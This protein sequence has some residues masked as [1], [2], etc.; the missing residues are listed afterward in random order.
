[1]AVQPSYQ[2]QNF[3][4]DA[5]AGQVLD[6]ETIEHWSNRGSKGYADIHCDKIIA[7]D[8]SKVIDWWMVKNKALTRVSFWNSTPMHIE[9]IAEV[10]GKTHIVALNIQGE[11][12]KF[13]QVELN[14]ALN[15][16]FSGLAQ[17]RNI[18]E[19]HVDG[20]AFKGNIEGMRLFANF[21]TSNT[22][23]Q[24]IYSNPYYYDSHHYKLL[25]EAMQE[26]KTILAGFSCNAITFRSH[27][28]TLQALLE[29]NRNLPKAG[30]EEQESK[31]EEVEP[32]QAE[33]VALKEMRQSLSGNADLHSINELSWKD[34]PRIKMHTNII[35]DQRYIVSTANHWKPHAKKNPCAAP[36]ETMVKIGRYYVYCAKTPE[37]AIAWYKQCLKYNVP[38]CSYRIMFELGLL[39][40]TGCGVE[41]DM[42]Q[43]FAYYFAAAKRGVSDAFDCVGRCYEFGVGVSR[44]LET[45]FSYYKMAEKK[46][47][48]YYHRACYNLGACFL[49]GIGTAKDIDQAQHYLELAQ[50]SYP[51]PKG[52]FL[53]ID[54]NTEAT[55][56]VV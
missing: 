13:P 51:L 2:M 41:Q 16:L 36:I 40:E 52:L 1:M 14:S 31:V 22:T 28:S 47:A 55:S 25:I 53:K 32:I 20:Q 24:Y 56:I 27:H 39:Y 45:A 50:R 17:N 34:V 42:K 19:L 46:R 37:L 43:A 3:F 49:F 33:V 11:L 23:L 18:I 4:D 26:N 29:R 12:H 54:G 10:A 30:A 8:L 6:K 44:N 15:H 5:F 21:L 35:G 7:R 38:A 9:G 48:T